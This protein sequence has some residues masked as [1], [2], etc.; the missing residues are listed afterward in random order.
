MKN[1]STNSDIRSYLEKSDPIL[2]TLIEQ[3]GDLSVELSSDPFCSLVRT[4]CGQQLSKV[5]ADT[6][7]NRLENLT[8]NHIDPE[9]LLELDIAE[10][11]GIGLSN[12]KSKYLK[13][14]SYSV[15]NHDIDIYNFDFQTDDNIRKLLLEV[16]GIGEWTVEMFLIFCLGRSNVFSLTDAGLHRSIMWLYGLNEKPTKEFLIELSDQWAP[17]KTYTSLYLWEAN[18]RKLIS[19]ER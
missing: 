8:E 15:Q 7:W 9:N 5:V 19:N 11:R 10:L 4:I 1:L 2:G 18:N 17:Y 14:L 6:I 3:C 13:Q 16:N 12:A